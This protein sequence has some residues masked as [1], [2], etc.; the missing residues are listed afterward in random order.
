MDIEMDVE[1]H[2]HDTEMDEEDTPFAM[3]IEDAPIVIPSAIRGGVRLH[4]QGGKRPQKSKKT[5]I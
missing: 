4:R 3:D 1:G 2:E 5:L